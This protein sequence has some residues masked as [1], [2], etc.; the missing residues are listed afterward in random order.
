MVLTFA[1]VF[2]DSWPHKQAWFPEYT[3]SGDFLFP[4]IYFFNKVYKIF[5]I[6][7]EVKVNEH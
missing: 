3:T 2:L 5:I 4:N 6:R 1:L 7:V